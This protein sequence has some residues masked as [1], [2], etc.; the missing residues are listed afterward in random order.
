MRRKQ[1]FTLIELLVVIGI[2][3][4]L[5][6]LMFPVL[7][8]VR[9]KAQSTSC[10]S[11]LK[12]IGYS[13]MSYLN[14]NE[15][16]FP[17]AAQKPTINTSLTPISEMLI[18]YAKDAKVFQCPEDK[19]TEHYWLNNSIDKTFYDAEGSSY[20]YESMLGGVVFNDKIGPG[21]KEPNLALML[22]DYECFH[23]KASEANSKNYLFADGH[24]E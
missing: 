19:K 13:M 4:V 12:Q 3:G 23:N 10:I 16:I 5:G 18:L 6:G 14:D 1:I 22:S 15:S 7:S 24:V 11:N 17:N 8:N 9:K 2:I 21:R 20:E